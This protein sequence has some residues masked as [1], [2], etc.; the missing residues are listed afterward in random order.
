M[1]SLAASNP[2][3]IYESNTPPQDPEVSVV[4]VDE[5]DDDT[6]DDD[7]DDGS[8]NKGRKDEGSNDEETEEDAAFHCAARDIMNRAGQRVGTAAV[9][10]GGGDGW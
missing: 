4:S 6:S 1:S 5:D 2:A 8:G 7:E 10:W 9:D 3:A